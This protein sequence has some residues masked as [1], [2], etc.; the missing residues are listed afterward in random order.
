MCQAREDPSRGP[1]GRRNGAHLE[2]AVT[3]TA[4]SAAAWVLIPA[5]PWGSGPASS[6]QPGF[7]Y[8]ALGVC[9]LAPLAG[10]G[11]LA[12]TP[13]M[14][15]LQGPSTGPHCLSSFQTHSLFLLGLDVQPWSKQG[16]GPQDKELLGLPLPLG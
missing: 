10:C 14:G 5:V 6:L 1:V 7:L 8:V 15:W 4:P 11:V 9:F 12:P 16:Q 2:S 13:T 3:G